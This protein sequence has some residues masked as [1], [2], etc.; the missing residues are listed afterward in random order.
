MLHFWPHI[1]CCIS[2]HTAQADRSTCMG[3]A[4]VVHEYVQT[5]IAHSSRCAP[6]YVSTGEHRILASQIASAVECGQAARCG[7]LDHLRGCVRCQGRFTWFR[8]EFT[9]RARLNTPCT[10]R[11]ACRRKCTHT[12]EMRELRCV[13]CSLFC[14]THRKPKHC[15]LWGSVHAVKAIACTTVQRA[16]VGIARRRTT[17]EI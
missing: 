8:V 11:A 1:K 16:V 2:G 6:G 13:R 14:A 3:L 15:S 17:L 7:P 4:L 5:C 10:S 12:S 9:A